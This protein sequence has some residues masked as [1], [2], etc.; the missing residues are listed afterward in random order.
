[1]GLVGG[2][3]G[4]NTRRDRLRIVVGVGLFVLGFSVVFIGGGYL[5]GTAGLYMRAWL[6]VITP[7]A[8]LIIILMGLLFIGK[9]PGLQ[10]TIRPSL[11]V[12]TG[13]I[14]AP[15]LGIIFAIGWTPCLGPTL[16]AINY[17]VFDLGD[18]GRGTLLAATYCLGLGIPFLLVALGFGWVVGSVGWLKR[19]IRLINIIG[20]SLLIAIGALMV[21]G[22][23][24][25]LIS[26][27][28]AAINRTF[29]SF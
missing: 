12:R 18:P 10:R 29:V 25:L 19:H 8:G 2:V 17:L 9:F 21:T 26:A 15:L 11:T 6:D 24:R 1:M 3:T 23:W 5:F 22:L 14:G 20:G 4:T 7:I 28:G 13:L 27:F 16:I